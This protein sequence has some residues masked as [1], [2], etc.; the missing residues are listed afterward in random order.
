MCHFPPGF[1]E[2]FSFLALLRCLSWKP[3]CGTASL[4][5][6]VMH[7]VVAVSDGVEQFVG[8]RPVGGRDT[9]KR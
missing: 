4:F 8:K 5:R 9:H 6:A 1:S 2:G 7:V 3:M